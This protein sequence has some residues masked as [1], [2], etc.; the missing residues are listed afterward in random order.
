MKE[1]DGNVVNL[2]RDFNKDEKKQNSPTLVT[3]DQPM[4]NADTFNLE[5]SK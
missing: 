1:Q 2:Q 3:Q 5:S 4:S